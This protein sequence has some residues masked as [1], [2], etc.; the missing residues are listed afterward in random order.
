[1]LRDRRFRN[2]VVY[3]VSTVVVTALATGTSK[4]VQWGVDALRARAEGRHR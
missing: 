4:F 2:W 3:A 1:M